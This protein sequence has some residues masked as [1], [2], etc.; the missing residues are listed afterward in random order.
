M[1]SLVVLLCLTLSITTAAAQSATPLDPDTACADFRHRS[2]RFIDVHEL[3]DVGR[4]E[5][6]AGHG[7][8]IML[9]PDI[10][11]TLPGTL[12]QFFKLHECGHHVLG[13]LFAP[14]DHSERD[15][16]EWAIRRGRTLGLFTRTEIESWRPYFANSLG[17]NFGHLP[18][19][20]RVDFLLRSYDEP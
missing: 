17:S 19:P 20:R 1:R 3:G 15:A 7:P 13:H 6:I 14:T 12:Q 11:E 10:M 4:A 8:V 2:V 18:G 16:D 9:D 5:Y